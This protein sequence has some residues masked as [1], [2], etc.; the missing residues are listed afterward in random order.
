S[1]FGI[2]GTSDIHFVGK[3]DSLIWVDEPD[4][5]QD[6]KNGSDI[7]VVGLSHVQFL[8]ANTSLKV[9]MAGTGSRFRTNIDSLTPNYDSFGTFKS[10]I[11]ES[12][13]TLKTELNTKTG[14]K[15]SLRSGF[16]A[17]RLFYNTDVSIYS[18]GFGKR[19]SL[20]D[21]KGNGDL[22]QAYSQWH[23]KAG[24]KWTFDAGLHALYFSINK[25]SSL[26]PRASV[27]FQTAGNQSISAGYGRHSRVLPLNVYLRETELASGEIVQTNKNLDLL[28][29]NHYVLAYDWLIRENLRLKVETYYQQLQNVGV[30]SGRPA[31]TSVL[32]LGADFGDVIGPDSLVSTGTGFNQG[33]ELTL[34]KFFSN[35]YYILMTGSLY[36]SKYKGSDGVERNT[37]FNNR[38]AFNFL[39][40]KEIPVGKTKQNAIILSFRQVSTGGMWTTPID[41]EASRASGF[42]VYMQDQAYTE[43]L[44]AYWRT[45]I[46]IGFRKNKKKY[47]EEFGFD[48]QNLLN[49][50]NVFSRSFNSISGNIQNNYQV[51]IFPMGLYRITF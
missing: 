33:V 40:G 49:R 35:N 41:L 4:R 36:D 15:S 27:K 29:A 3:K 12:R 8:S 18:P 11:T 34:E 32:N 38:Y 9:I 42:T 39:A 26:E 14:N 1:F 21:A 45:D 47:T 23:L 17:S 13:A 30:Q 2:A 51:G 46:R 31:S 50:Q 24:E 43:Q 5:R 20:S 28:R 10:A 6:L 16:I 37:A 7:A 25:K 22:L 48:I 44:P 19:I